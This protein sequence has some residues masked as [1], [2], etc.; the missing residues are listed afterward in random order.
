MKKKGT[1]DKGLF[2]KLAKLIYKHGGAPTIHFK[3][4]AAKKRFIARGK[5][6]EIADEGLKN[7]GK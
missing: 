3:D 7:S 1:L 2:D 5:L 4:E 6:L